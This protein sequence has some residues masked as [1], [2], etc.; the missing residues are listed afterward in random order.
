M[1]AAQKDLC[2]I[3]WIEFN[4]LLLC[5]D[6]FHFYYV[7]LY[8]QLN[9]IGCSSIRFIQSTAHTYWDKYV[10]SYIYVNCFSSQICKA[11]IFRTLCTTTHVATSR[12]R[13]IILIWT[14]VLYGLN[15]VS[16]HR[17]RKRN[18]CTSIDHRVDMKTPFLYTF[19]ATQ[20]SKYG[21]STFI[22]LLHHFSFSCRGWKRLARLF[23]LHAFSTVFL[24][25]QL[26]LYTDGGSTI[27]CG[28]LVVIRSV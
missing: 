14:A 27:L 1:L 28:W 15:L 3:P 6:A 12:A 11:K 26:L 20:E 2:I 9:C 4:S 24:F 10:L 5:L 23:V 17:E 22:V 8:I 18:S 19:S 7:G 21:K 25:L 16:Q 13:R